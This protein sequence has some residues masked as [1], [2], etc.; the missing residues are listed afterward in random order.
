LVKLDA[1]LETIPVLV[2]SGTILPLAQ[3]DCL[4]LHLYRPPDGERGCGMLYSDL[5][6]GY[7]PWRL[8]NFVLQHISSG[9]EFTWQS[10]GEYAWPYRKITLHMHGFKGPHTQI[11]ILPEQRVQIYEPHS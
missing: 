6:D 4:E 3:G 8:D 1:L 11:E 5:G 10:Q 2:R 7:G 9:Y